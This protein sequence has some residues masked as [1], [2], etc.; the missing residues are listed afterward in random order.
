MLLKLNCHC[1]SILNESLIEKIILKLRK[2]DKENLVNSFFLSALQTLFK[3]HNYNI[4]TIICAWKISTY[5][6]SV[7]CVLK[8]KIIYKFANYKSNFTFEIF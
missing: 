5:I 6:C 2:V 1:T 4:V 7:G 8:F 3:T